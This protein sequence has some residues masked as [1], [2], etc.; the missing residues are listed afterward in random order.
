MAVL[1]QC[2]SCRCTFNELRV[3]E[4]GHNRRLL[5]TP[6]DRHL[7]P[8]AGL[9]AAHVRDDGSICGPVRFFGVEQPIDRLTSESELYASG[10]HRFNSR[11][12]SRRSSMPAPLSSPA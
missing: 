3:V 10:D 9:P 5:V 2:E 4:K 1:G 8:A 6:N 7:R 12:T 11:R